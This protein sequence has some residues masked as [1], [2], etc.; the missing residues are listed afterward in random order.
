MKEIIK[1]IILLLILNVA[2]VI[3]GCEGAADNAMPDGTAAET[4]AETTAETT[5]YIQVYGDLFKAKK[6]LLAMTDLPFTRTYYTARSLADFENIAG[7]INSA[8]QDINEENINLYFIKLENAVSSLEMIRLNLPVIYITCG[9]DIDRSYQTASVAVVDSDHGQTDTVDNEAE[10]RIRGNSTSGAPKKPFNIMFTQKQALLGMDFGKRWILLA[11]AL[12]KTLMRNKL[13][14]DFCATLNMDFVPQG[15]YCEVWL[16]GTFL[17]SYLLTEAVTDGKYRVDIDTGKNEFLM[18]LE[19][20]RTSENETYV[21]SP[22]GVRLKIKKPD[23]MNNSQKQYLTDLLLDIEVCLENGSDEELPQCIDVESFVDFYVFMELFKDID[24]YFSSTFFY[25]KN[26]VLYAGP[27]WDLDLISGNVSDAVDEVK[28]KTYCNVEGYGTNS[29]DSTEG[30]WMQFGWFK[31]LF[32]RDSFKNKVISRFNQLQPMIVNL[33]D[34]N[35]L[36]T[37]RIDILL[38]K[39]AGT[40]ADNYVSAGWSMTEPYSPYERVPDDSFEE[41]VEFLRSWLRD[42]NEWL[43]IYFGTLS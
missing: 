16:N 24:A 41:N 33:Y 42:R 9:Q 6:A 36:G 4:E 27:P 37:N 22:S 31:M 17:G 1:K 14:F 3:S 10:I 18:E 12:D 39:Y 19:S 32:E 2:F 34:N 5:D 35:E 29:S 23:E 8:V 20:D 13:V 26:D 21:K 30:I 28:Y 40:F 15:E 43:K 38:N 25:I 11:N 7:E